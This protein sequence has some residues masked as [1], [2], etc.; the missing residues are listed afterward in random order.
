MTLRQIAVAHTL[1]DVQKAMRAR[2][3]ELGV[4]L[5]DLDAIAGFTDG[6]ASKLLAPHPKKR[7]G[8]RSL[9]W[10]MEAMGLELIVAVKN[11]TPAGLANPPTNPRP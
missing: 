2:Y 3:Q 4:T 11:E 6:H 9:E 7:L 1:D 8:R 10:L 5:A